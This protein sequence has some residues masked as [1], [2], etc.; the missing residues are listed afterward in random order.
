MGRPLRA[1]EQ[2]LYPT[3]LTSAPRLIWEYFPNWTDVPQV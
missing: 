3:Q 1:P 2:V